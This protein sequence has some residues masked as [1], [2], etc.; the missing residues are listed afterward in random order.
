MNVDILV[1]TYRNEK[2]LILARRELVQTETGP[3]VFVV[4]NN[5]EIMPQA[6]LVAVQTGE[7]KGLRLEIIGGLSEGDI[8]VSEG[9]NQINEETRL[10]IVPAILPGF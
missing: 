3:A 7:E 4:D 10:N 1:E 2:A 6:H 9:V 5:S 8:I